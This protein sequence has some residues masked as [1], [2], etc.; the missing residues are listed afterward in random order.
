MDK[1][2]I[3]KEELEFVIK[4][5]KLYHINTDDFLPI[6]NKT[7]LYGKMTFEGLANALNEIYPT[8]NSITDLWL[9]CDIF[10]E[11]TIR[12]FKLPLCVEW[13]RQNVEPIRVPNIKDATKSLHALLVKIKQEENMINLV[14][15][16][17]LG[18][19]TRHLNKVVRKESKRA[20]ILEQLTA[21]FKKE[22][23]YIGFDNAKEVRV[24]IGREIAYSR[25]CPTDTFDLSRGVAMCICDI[26]NKKSEMKKLNNH[27][28]GIAK[29]ISKVWNKKLSSDDLLRLHANGVA[30]DY[31]HGGRFY[32]QSN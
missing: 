23:I 7:V 8:V 2:E 12:G 22:T 20:K 17:N 1:I 15:Q 21:I 26:L 9:A 29:S 18:K 25:C 30:K 28:H 13:W 27:L 11:L 5:A 31:L 16:Y 32:G 6:M 19:I 3:L 10:K 4:T 14:R 24:V